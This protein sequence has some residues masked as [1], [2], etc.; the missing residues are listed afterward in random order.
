MKPHDLMTEY[1]FFC[2]CGWIRVWHSGSQHYGNSV[3]CD[4]L[5]LQGQ[6]QKSCLRDNMPSLRWKSGNDLSRSPVLSL[7]ASL[8]KM[9]VDWRWSVTYWSWTGY[10]DLD[11]FVSLVRAEFPS[12]PLLGRF[13]FAQLL[14]SVWKTDCPTS[15]I[16]IWAQQNSCHQLS[17]THTRTP[18]ILTSKK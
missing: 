2:R 17:H 8:C 4:R 15:D 11:S 6:P 7:K 18:Y 9:I 1:V 3:C 13:P 10:C 5:E 16:G 14:N 12:F